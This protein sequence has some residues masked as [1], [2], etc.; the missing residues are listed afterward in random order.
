MYLKDKREAS[1]LEPGEGKEERCESHLWKCEE[2]PD[3]GTLQVT[4]RT[5][6]FIPST[7]GR[8]W[9]AFRKKSD[10]TGRY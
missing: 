4:L 7:L 2:K 3:P 1:V 8:H 6:D 5:L 10:I 9:R